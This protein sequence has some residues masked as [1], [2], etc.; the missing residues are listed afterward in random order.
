MLFKATI[1]LRAIGAIGIFRRATVATRAD[2][3]EQATK[4]IL[5]DAA[6][7]GWEPRNCDAPVQIG[8]IEYTSIGP[9]P[10]T[11]AAQAAVAAKLALMAQTP[12]N[13]CAR[14]DCSVLGRCANVL[15]CGSL[16]AE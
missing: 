16:V 4:F 12:W 15:D 6:A 5:D 13:Y 11:Y 14:D 2:S 1:E 3:P 10:I 7:N 9:F 8:M